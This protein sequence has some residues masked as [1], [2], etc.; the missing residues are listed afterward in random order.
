MSLI[1]FHKAYLY[2][3]L[4]LLSLNQANYLKR[5]WIMGLFKLIIGWPYRYINPTNMLF[6]HISLYK[7]FF[8]SIGIV[9]N[10][11]VVEEIIF[12]S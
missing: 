9:K 12:N 2:L 6:I 8:R 11:I 7:K 5:E 3:A 4:V 1:S 10:Y